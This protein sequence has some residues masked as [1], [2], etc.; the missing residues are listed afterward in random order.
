MVVRAFNGK[1]EELGFGPG[2][3]VIR[4]QNIASYTS[5]INVTVSHRPGILGEDLVSAIGQNQGEQSSP[6]GTRHPR[7][8]LERD[9]IDIVEPQGRLRASEVPETLCEKLGIRMTARSG[10]WLTSHRNR[11]GYQNKP[12]SLRIS[13]QTESLRVLDA[14]LPIPVPDTGAMIFIYRRVDDKA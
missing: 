5:E 1:V 14:P 10:K 3:K 13:V 6:T 4:A 9:I 2:I 12:T 11:E 8:S 7:V